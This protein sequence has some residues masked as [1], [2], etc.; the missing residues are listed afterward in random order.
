MMEGNSQTLAGDLFRAKSPSKRSWPIALGHRPFLRD[1]SSTFLPG[2]YRSQQ[3][4]LSRHRLMVYAPSAWKADKNCA[5]VWMHF[6]TRVEECFSPK[7][8]LLEEG[9]RV[10]VSTQFLV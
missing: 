4:R 10:E 6:I 5:K 9:Q 2:T 8:R 3:K 1:L 7:K